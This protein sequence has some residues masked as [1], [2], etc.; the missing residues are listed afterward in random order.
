MTI[1]SELNT[2]IY[3]KNAE[4][5]KTLKEWAAVFPTHVGVFPP[6]GLPLPKSMPLRSMEHDRGRPW[7]IRLPWPAW[8]WKLGRIVLALDPGLV[9][10]VLHLHHHQHEG[11]PRHVQDQAAQA[12]PVEASV[13]D[14]R[15]TRQGREAEETQ[16]PFLPVI[17]VMPWWVWIIERNPRREDSF[18]APSIL[19]GIPHHSRSDAV[20]GLRLAW[21]A[22]IRLFQAIDVFSRVANQA[23]PGHGLVV[24]GPTILRPSPSKTW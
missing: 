13:L 4:S 6:P 12:R 15:R 20:S 17:Q 1:L 23:C 21:V 19:P 16:A 11:D 2:Q 18:Q 3:T 24:H 8:S 9:D 7:M 14:P 10:H 5:V 22:L